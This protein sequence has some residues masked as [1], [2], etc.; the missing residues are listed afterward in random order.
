MRRWYLSVD[1]LPL[2]VACPSFLS[3]TLASCNLTIL[4][5]GG[6]VT[7]FEVTETSTWLIPNFQIYN[8]KEFAS[9]R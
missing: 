2:V 5:A 4:L 3:S 8:G 9:T 6:V 1:V 7:F